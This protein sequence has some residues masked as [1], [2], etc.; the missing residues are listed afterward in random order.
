M[1]FEK[2]HIPY[3]GY[4][5][6]PFC[7]WQGSLSGEHPIRLAASCAGAFLD[8]A[9]CERG[10][11]GRHPFRHDGAAAQEL[12]GRALDRRPDRCGAGDG[13]DPVAGL[14]HLGARRRLGRLGPGARR[15]RADAGAC[16]GPHLQRAH[17]LLSRPLGARRPRRHRALGVGQFQR[18]PARRSRH[19]PDRRK[20]CGAVR[21]FAPRAG[22]PCASVRRSNTAWRSPTTAR[23]SAAT[24]SMSRSAGSAGRRPSPATR[25]CASAPKSVCRRSRRSSATAPSPPPRR[26]IRP[27]AM[28]ACC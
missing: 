14:R 7:R 26:P 18:G 5:S 21:I 17:A 15:R 2:V 10:E 25:A 12:L 9:G 11:P 23:S 22:R 4:W 20:H 24:W 8:K 19:D 1:R 27:T 16:R 28:P 3:G 6:T 13:A